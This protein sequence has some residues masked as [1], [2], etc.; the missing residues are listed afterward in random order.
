M[1]VDGAAAAVSARYNLGGGQ[2]ATKEFGWCTPSM[3]GMEAQDNGRKNAMH[4]PTLEMRL[5]TKRY[6]QMMTLKSW[7]N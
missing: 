4:L 6:H 5:P 7:H 1:M 3:L 2:G